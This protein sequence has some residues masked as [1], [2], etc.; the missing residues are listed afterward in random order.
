[1]NTTELIKEILGETSISRSDYPKVEWT[2]VGGNAFSIIGTASKAWGSKDKEVSN[3]ICSVL[4]SKATS[5]DALLAT[6]IQICPMG[7]EDEG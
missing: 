1:M 5:Y 2:S 7:D 6:C 4:M 3:R